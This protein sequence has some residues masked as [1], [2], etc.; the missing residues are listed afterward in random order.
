L[1]EDL[2]WTDVQVGA[3][4]QAG[5]NEVVIDSIRKDQS[6]WDP[7]REA[8]IVRT[9]DGREFRIDAP[10]VIRELKAFALK[11]KYIRGAVLK[12]DAIGVGRE[13]RY[14]N[15]EVLPRREAKKR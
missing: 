8:L 12:C 15:V 11:H 14:K 3:G 13:R 1:S 7:A 9:M 10:V 5:H 4:L 2:S 6:R